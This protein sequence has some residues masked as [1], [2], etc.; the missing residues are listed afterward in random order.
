[1]ERSAN[2]TRPSTLTPPLTFHVLSG[3]DELIALDFANMVW[4]RSATWPVPHSEYGR[5]IFPSPWLLRVAAPGAGNSYHYKCM[6]C[7][8]EATAKRLG[9]FTGTIVNSTQVNFSFKEC[10]KLGSTLQHI[11][12]GGC[13]LNQIAAGAVQVLIPVMDALGFSGVTLLPKEEFMREL[14]LAL[15]RA[16]QRALMGSSHKMLVT[17]KVGVL[18]AVALAQENKQEITQVRTTERNS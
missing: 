13:Q 17:I 11:A 16:H 8:D 4:P 3:A 14:H 10:A 9:R 5:K 15:L 7:P 1:M 2:V 18:E 12:Q 6:T